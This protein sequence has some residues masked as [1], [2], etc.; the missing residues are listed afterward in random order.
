MEEI[1]QVEFEGSKIRE[2][3]DI[4]WKLDSAH[5]TEPPKISMEFLKKIGIFQL[6]EETAGYS[7]RLILTALHL[8]YVEFMAAI[9]FLPVDEISEELLKVPNKERFK[10]IVEYLR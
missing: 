10:A 6:T 8:S 3:G 9:A 2:N 1:N 4:Y 7:G 5:S